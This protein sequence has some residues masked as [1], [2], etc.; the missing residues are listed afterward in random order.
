MLCPLCL[1]ECNSLDEMKGVL[2]PSFHC[3]TEVEMPDGEPQSHF[4][5]FSS[6]GWSTGM[7]YEENA[8]LLP[9]RLDNHLNSNVT[10]R[11]EKNG[12]ERQIIHRPTSHVMV[13]GPDNRQRH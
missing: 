5:R 7:Y 12:M 4:I 1:K 9:Y 13:Y 2:P 6:G 3:P 11:T 8:I 10:T